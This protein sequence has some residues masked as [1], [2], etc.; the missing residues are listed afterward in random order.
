MTTTLAHTAKR[1]ALAI[2]ALAAATSIADTPTLIVWNGEDAAKGGGWAAP[3]KDT[4]S[5]KAQT[6]TAK[7]GDTALE[8]RL[9][10]G[11]WMGGGWN[12]F[13]WWPEDAGTDTTDHTHLV[14][15]IKQTGNVEN[16]T[17][18]LTCS[19]TKNATETVQVAT[20]MKAADPKN[21]GWREVA[22]P[23]AD[24]KAAADKPFDR[25]TVWGIDFGSWSQD[26]R[27]FSLFIDDIGFAKREPIQGW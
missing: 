17:V 11:A 12:W 4:N 21:E 23:L 24:F 20:Y 8:L 9:E 6:A 19:S 13:G 25:K 26:E 2:A 10:G 16:L 27:A 5:F 7:S 14:F 22:I 3:Q 1:L 18:A 15:W